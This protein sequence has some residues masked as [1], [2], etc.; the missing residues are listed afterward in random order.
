VPDVIQR[1]IAVV[2]LV[3]LAPLLAVLGLGVLVRSGPPILHRGTRW[4]PGGT[5]VLYKFRTMRRNPD[6][7]ALTAAGDARITEIGRFLRRTKLDELPQL[8]NVARGDMLLVGPRPEDPR[9]I[10]WTNPT[11]RR[12]FSAKPGITGPAAL[13]YR[14]EEGLLAAE[15]ARLSGGASG[16]STDAIERAYSESVLPA[17]L[18]L[19]LQYL[20]ERSIG[21]DL[22]ILGRTFRLLFRRSGRA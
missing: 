1:V 18:A 8:W 11:H 14:D 10:D 17:K 15:A 7:V 20:D 6:G 5:F 21:T 22:T 9:Y 12:V 19:D 4:G 3:L 13:A 2:A 16:V